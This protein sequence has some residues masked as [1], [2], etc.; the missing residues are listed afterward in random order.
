MEYIDMKNSLES[1][2]QIGSICSVRIRPKIKV[3]QAQRPR[4]ETDRSNKV[5]FLEELVRLVI[6]NE[7][8]PCL[9][10][11]VRM[12]IVFALYDYNSKNKERFIISL[13]SRFQLRILTEHIKPICR[14]DS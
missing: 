14:G 10:L 12:S 5:K 3:I 7:L 9:E 6:K 4:K 2:L 13:I 11:K 8:G 1:K